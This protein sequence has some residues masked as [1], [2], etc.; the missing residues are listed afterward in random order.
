MNRIVW[1]IVALLCASW[2]QAEVY[3]WVDANGKTH[4]GD[5]PPAEQKTEKVDVSVTGKGLEVATDLQRRDEQHKASSVDHEM[6]ERYQRDAGKSLQEKTSSTA[7]I[8]KCQ[9]EYGMSCEAM[10]KEW[11]ENIDRC[12]RNRGGSQCDDKQYQNDFLRPRTFKEKAEIRNNQAF[13]RLKRN[14]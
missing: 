5:R 13:E 10:E 9:Q 12:K 14:W 4:F 1:L 2:C 8:E 6:Q 3:K 7:L 11:K